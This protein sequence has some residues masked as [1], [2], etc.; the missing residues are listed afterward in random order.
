MEERKPILKILYENTEKPVNQIWL[1]FPLSG[2]ERA[3]QKMLALTKGHEKESSI[4][5]RIA[6]VESPIPNLG[7]YLPADGWFQEI[8]RLAEKIEGMDREEQMLFGKLSASTIF[9]LNAAI[10]RAV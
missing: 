1:T 2:R 3:E 8:S 6:R 4:S 5:F 7:Q 9:T 10:F